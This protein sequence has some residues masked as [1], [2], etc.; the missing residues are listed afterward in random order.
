M[1]G[2][3]LY[4]FGY[5]LTYGDCSIKKAEYQD[6]KILAEI[7]NIG[8]CD[9]G[10]VLQV[11]IKNLDSAYAVRNHSLCAFQRVWLNRGESQTIELAIPEQAFL[12][13]NEEGQRIQDGS[14]YHLYVG[15]GQPDQR[16]K[17]LTGKSCMEI[18][19]EL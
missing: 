3:A 10:E 14:R 7:E 19:V 8:A 6:G 9:T 5:G 11:Y 13:V 12:V 17:E 16:T 18:P 1:T 4:P 15:F 2:E